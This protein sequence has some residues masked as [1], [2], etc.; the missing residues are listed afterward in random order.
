MTFYVYILQSKKD[1][2]FY[3]GYTFDLNKRINEHNSGKV[4]STLYRRPLCMVYFESCINQQDALHREKYLK[5]AWGKKY[6]KSRLKN[7]LMGQGERVATE[8]TQNRNS[9]GFRECKDSAR[10]GGDVAGRARR[11]AESRIGKSVVSEDNYLDIK[12]RKLIEN[13]EKKTGK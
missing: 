8:I 9:D 2:N 4:K 13:K 10:E 5:T 1:G 6:I 11:D 7:Y 12:K 3:T